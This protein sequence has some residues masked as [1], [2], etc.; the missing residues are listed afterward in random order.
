MSGRR[1]RPKPARRSVI[2]AGRTLSAKFGRQHLAAAKRAGELSA[3]RQADP[4][5]FRS[6]RC[7]MGKPTTTK[8]T[9]EAP[10]PD[11]AHVGK[12]GRQLHDLPQL[13]RLQR[14]GPEPAAAGDRLARHPHGAGAQQR[15]YGPALAPVFPDNRKGPEGDVSQ[16]RLRL[17]PATTAFK[18]RSTASPCSGGVR[19]P[20]APSAHCDHRSFSAP[21]RCS[22]VGVVCIGVGVMRSRSVR[23]APS[24]S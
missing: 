5:P 23:P 1:S 13:P 10:G 21:A 9:E 14:L 2:A 22:D 4:G 3:E 12:P 11:D 7:R 18:S 15:L 17:R 6:P 19:R 20:P 16:G 8:E 24:G